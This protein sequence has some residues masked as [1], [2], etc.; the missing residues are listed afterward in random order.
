MADPTP[1]VLELETNEVALIVGEEDGEM[2][3][4]VVP[5]TEIPEDAEDMPA[6]PEIIL[7]L[8]MR[9]LKDPSFHDEMLDWYYENQDD[10][11]AED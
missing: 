7:A 11:E 5:G 6:A 10:D 2:T 9:L 3:V 4:R 8:A 1:T